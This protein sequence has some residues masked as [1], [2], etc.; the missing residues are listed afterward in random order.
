MQLN[1]IEKNHILRAL[2]RAI[3]CVDAQYADPLKQA[4][5]I[6][7]AIEPHSPCRLCMDFSAGPESGHCARWKQDIPPEW[8]EVGCDQWLDDVPF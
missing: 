6:V 4:R 7:D 1:P 3:E 5:G 2:E 8:L